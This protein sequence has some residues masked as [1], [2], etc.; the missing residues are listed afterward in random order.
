MKPFSK[1]KNEKGMVKNIFWHASEPRNI[2]SKKTSNVTSFAKDAEFSVAFIKT[3]LKKGCL[4]FYVMDG[5]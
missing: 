5:S 1:G 3:S 2:G 4:K